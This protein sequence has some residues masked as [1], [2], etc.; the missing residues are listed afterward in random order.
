MRCHSTFCGFSQDK[1]YT[2]NNTEG[3]SN[4]VREDKKQKNT[5]LNTRLFV[6]IINNKYVFADK[7]D[8]MKYENTFNAIEQYRESHTD[9]TNAEKIKDVP[10]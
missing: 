3:I 10:S 8:I 2:N 4:A 5:F 1:T 6:S 7:K 9:T